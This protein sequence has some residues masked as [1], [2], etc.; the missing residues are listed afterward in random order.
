VVRGQVIV[1]RVYRW[2]RRGRIAGV[3]EMADGT[4]QAPFRNFDE[5]RRAMGTMLVEDPSGTGA[6]R[7]Q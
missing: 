2:R 7:K 6:D 5:L 4:K 3:L 1:I